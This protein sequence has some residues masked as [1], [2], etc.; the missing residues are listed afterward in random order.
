MQ[1][2]T[3]QLP[4]ALAVDM[5]GRLDSGSAGTAYDSM[6]TIGKSG[7]KKIVLNLKKVEF[8]SSAGLRVILTLAKLLENS[9]GEMRICNANVAVKEVLETSGF[10]SLIKIFDDEASAVAFWT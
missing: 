2:K 5:V 10:N 8:V 9:R 3:R 1:I 6:V 7:I 4:N